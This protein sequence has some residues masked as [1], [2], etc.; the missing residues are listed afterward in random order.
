M[1]SWIRQIMKWKRSIGLAEAEQCELVTDDDQF[2]RGLRT[3]YPFIV[4]FV[5]L[6]RCRR[7]VR[8]DDALD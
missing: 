2:A 6:P 1:S 3:P 5:E 4:S 8:P 7:S